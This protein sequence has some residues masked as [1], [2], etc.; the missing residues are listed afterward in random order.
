MILFGRIR[1]SNNATWFCHN[2]TSKFYEN[3]LA[4]G[5]KDKLR[6]LLRRINVHSLY[7]FKATR[8]NFLLLPFIISASLI[9]FLREIIIFIFKTKY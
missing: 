1:F 3:A 4:R 7:I 6:T 9:G 8:F 5:I 2:Y